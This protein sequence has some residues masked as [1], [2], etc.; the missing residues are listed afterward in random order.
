MADLLGNGITTYLMDKDKSLVAENE[1][2]DPYYRCFNTGGVETAVG[3]FLYGFVRMLRPQSILETGTH[4]GISSS[5]MAQALKDNNFGLLTTLEIEKQ[6]I[7]AS[8]R[9]WDLLGL[10]SYVICD[11]EYSLEYELVYDVDILFLDSEPEFRFKELMKFMPRLKPGGF[12]FIHDLHRHCN[13]VPN[14]EHGFAWPYG[15][16]PAI[17]RNWV[18]DGQLK[19]CYFGTPRG[20]TMFYKPRIDDYGWAKPKDELND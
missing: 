14:E 20:L 19:P 15:K 11:R 9:R 6:H 1:P 7:D 10:N 17:L 16:M 5:Y 2:S 18:L 12:A 13:Q 8:K 4:L 3:E